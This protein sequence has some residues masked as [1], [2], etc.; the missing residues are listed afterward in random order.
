MVARAVQHGV[1]EVLSQGW[2]G[3]GQ[4]NLEKGEG[5]RAPQMHAPTSEQERWRFSSAL[6]IDV[7]K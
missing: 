5:L 7:L 2:G 6:L 4:T 3:G 1:A